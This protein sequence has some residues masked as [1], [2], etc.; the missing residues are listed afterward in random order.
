MVSE[1]AQH[2]FQPTKFMDE[3]HILLRES[4]GFLNALPRQ[5]NLILRRMNSPEYRTKL[6]VEG[7]DDLRRSIEISFNLLFLGI[8][9]ASLIISSSLI[10]P[11]REGWMV[12]GMPGL[13]LVGYIIA[14][15]L[16][17]V[18]FINFIKKS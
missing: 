11:T 5:L 7:V 10:Y 9:M 17:I 13:S 15:I 12:G 18:A 8:I 16:G 2:Q 1:V 6:H 14:G 3:A 4:R